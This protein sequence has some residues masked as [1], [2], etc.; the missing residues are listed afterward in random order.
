MPGSREAPNVVAAVVPHSLE[1]ESQANFLVVVNTIGTQ[2]AVPIILPPI[3]SQSDS[4]KYELWLGPRNEGSNLNGM[5][6]LKVTL[7]V[8]SCVSKIK[9]SLLHLSIK[10]PR[11]VPVFYYHMYKIWCCPKVPSPKNSNP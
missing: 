1:L 5:E 9:Y 10:L 2:T 6:P 7:F 11:C 4:V 3:Q 8:D